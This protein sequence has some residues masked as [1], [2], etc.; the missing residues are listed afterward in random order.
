M[1]NKLLII[2]FIVLIASAF[3]VLD[4]VVGADELTKTYDSSLKEVTISD[5]SVEIAT[6]KLNTPLNNI[7]PMGYRKVAE[8]EVNSKET[9]YDALQSI[10][11]YDINLDMKEIEREFDYKIWELTDVKVPDYKEV[12]TKLV[13]GSESC[14]S[15]YS[16]S[17]IEKQYQWV[18]FETLDFNEGDNL[19][20]G[21]FT[22]VKKGDKIEWIPTFFGTEISEWAGWTED[23]YSA[24]IA[25]YSFE[26][27]SG[28][29]VDDLGQRNGTNN[30][31]TRGITGKVGDYCF[32][33]GGDGDSVYLSNTDLI[34]SGTSEVTVSLWAYHDDT[35]PVWQ[36]YIH[37]GYSEGDFWLAGKATTQNII[38]YSGGS[39][40]QVG[41]GNGVGTGAWYH[42]VFVRNGTTNSFIY[43]NNVSY[44]K[45][46][47]GSSHASNISIG[48]YWD[49]GGLDMNG[50][51][52]NV[53][54]FNIAFTQEMV[55][56]EWNNGNGLAYT[57][58]ITDT[59]TCTGLNNNWEVNLADYCVISDACELGTG[60][61][62]FTGSGNFTC[63]SNIN[64]TNLGDVGDG[65]I[66]W[67]FSSC[68]MQ[69]R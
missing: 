27:T 6:L 34:P 4:G 59:C 35:S 64:T 67:V 25:S 52:D 15:V 69:I 20:I 1:K 5:S 3:F 65:N 30:G 50:K 19:T 57:P 56:N 37:N 10:K 51:I 66:L 14:E 61:L 8:F 33:Y 49:A 36:T 60:S 54:I 23:M 42:I 58:P 26:Q 22:D 9:Y 31:A 38:F 7:V 12:C 16:G 43:V 53:H 17:H 44:V 46:A 21:I 32:D 63:N 28:V 41:D 55:S 39:Q 2:G 13:N 68:N 47:I 24:L 18:D 48:R 40:V 29:V 62:S 11:F 45:T